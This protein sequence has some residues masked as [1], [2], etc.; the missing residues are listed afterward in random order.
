MRNLPVN[1]KRHLTALGVVLLLGNMATA[2]E[3]PEE[4]LE[5]LRSAEEGQAERISAEVKSYWSRSGSPAMD[6]LLKRGREAMS[7]GNFPLAIEHLTALT[8]HAPQFAE[9]YHA[10]AE[11]YFR[12][13]LYG[14][15]LDDLE[16]V[17]ALN[18]QHYEAI[19]GL[20][21][22]VQEFGDLRRA[23]DLYRRVLTIHPNHE[24]ANEALAR[25][26][27]EGIGR[28]L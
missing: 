17:L 8:D 6:L 14:P 13:D 19:F 10:R 12:A 24:N 22:M 20:A 7:E 16:R 11:A 4:L 26:K 15:A 27:R 28:E 3:V 2:E 5:R 25:L 9:G 18:P 23:A 1:L 21:V